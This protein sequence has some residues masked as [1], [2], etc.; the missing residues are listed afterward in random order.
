MKDKVDRKI[1]TE[2]VAL[3]AKIYSYLTENIDENKAK[4]IEAT[5]LENEINYLGKNKLDVDSLKENHKEF[6]RKN[7]LILKSPKKFR[8][9]K[10]YLFTEEINK[11]ALSA[12][13]DKI[14]KSIDSIQTYAYRA[15]KD[16][17]C[18][19]EEF[20]CDIVIKQYKNMIN[21]DDVT[22]ENIKEHNLNWPQILDHPYSK[23]LIGVSGS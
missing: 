7:R 5:Q 8:T 22:R 20:K 6:I 23:V 18:K 21:F 19:D 3:R 4:G 13:N 16:L 1:M 14:I 11:I 2:F 10:H 17:M 15:S 9:L 12:D